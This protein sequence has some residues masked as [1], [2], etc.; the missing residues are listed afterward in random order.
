MLLHAYSK[1]KFNENYDPTVLETFVAKAR[2]G[3]FEVD[4]EI[5]DT[6][7]QEDFADIRRLVYP[8]TDG[9][10]IFH[11]LLLFLSVYHVL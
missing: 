1:K 10:C 4:F 9:K 7:G 11:F 5:Y 6:A 8:G 3:E 2:V